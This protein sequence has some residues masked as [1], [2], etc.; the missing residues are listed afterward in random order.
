MP[1]EF[2]V[3]KDEKIFE[4]IFTEII[5]D[6]ILFESYKEFI[7]NEE[8]FQKLNGLANLEKTDLSGLSVNGLKKLSEFTNNIIKQQFTT[9]KK[10]AIY[11]PHPSQ[12]GITG[13]YEVLSNSSAEDVMVFRDRNLAIEWLKK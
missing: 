3:N 13:M 1:I 2:I 6:D 9:I 7:T 10:T 5:T 11:A 4:A 12:F 8:L